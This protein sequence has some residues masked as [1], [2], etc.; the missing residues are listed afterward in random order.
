MSQTLVFFFIALAETFS[1]SFHG[2]G[3]ETQ[4]TLPQA[5]RY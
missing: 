3:S 1:P 4:T 2:R 5:L